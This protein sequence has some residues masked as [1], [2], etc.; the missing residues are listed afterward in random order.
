MLTLEELY[1]KGKR[2]GWTLEETKKLLE[3]L[4]LV[5]KQE[6]EGE[7]GAKETVAS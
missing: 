3:D 2:Y 1:E 6:V 5:K 4:I 7:G